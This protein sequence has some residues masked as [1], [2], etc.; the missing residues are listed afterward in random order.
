M[1]KIIIFAFQNLIYLINYWQE[2]V[3]ILKAKIVLMSEFVTEWKECVLAN[4]IFAVLGSN[5]T[6]IYQTVWYKVFYYLQI[7][8]DNIKLVF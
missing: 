4:S 7:I 3:Y 6:G 5:T 1:K 8:M 2:W